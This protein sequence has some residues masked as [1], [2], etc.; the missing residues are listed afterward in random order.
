MQIEFSED[1]KPTLKEYENQMQIQSAF[2]PNEEI[3]KRYLKR[4][5]GNSY[6]F[7]QRERLTEEI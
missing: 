6:D 4:G 2:F 3:K 7:D 5:F 1:L